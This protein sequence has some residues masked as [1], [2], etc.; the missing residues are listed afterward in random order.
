MGNF[1]DSI[2]KIYNFLTTKNFNNILCQ[3]P[4]EAKILDM[5]NQVDAYGNGTFN[6]PENNIDPS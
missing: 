1:F 3:N 2:I 4:T 6:F 5:I